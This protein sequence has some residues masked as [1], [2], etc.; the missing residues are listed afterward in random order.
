MI[1][2]AAEG[3]DL[4]SVNPGLLFWT[5]VTFLI[6]VIILKMFAWN[7]II[8]ALDERADKIHGDIDR[9]DKLRK[10]AEEAL[11]SY[12]EKIA[13]ANKEGNAILE[14]AKNDA[15]NLRNKMLEETQQEIRTLKEQSLRDIELSKQKAVQEIQEQVI[16]LSVSIA[17]QILE[18]KLKT[19]DHVAFVNNEIEKLKDLK[20]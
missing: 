20:V 2:L 12:R 10:E 6:V 5:L 11:E 19:E 3:L 9:A 17:G 18:K 4:L 15:N 8:H 13:N 16:E 7:P 14:E 1:Y